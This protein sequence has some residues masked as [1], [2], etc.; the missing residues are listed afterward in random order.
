MQR[1]QENVAA[2][3]QAAKN[4]HFAWEATRFCHRSE[5]SRR[6]ILSYRERHSWRERFAG[7]TARRAVAVITGRAASK[8]REQS[9]LSFELTASAGLSSA[10]RAVLPQAQ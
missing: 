7:G 9:F 10:R 3:E 8:K 1:C 2:Q 5:K 6:R 4:G